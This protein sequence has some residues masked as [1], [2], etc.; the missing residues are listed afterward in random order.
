MN[1]E[2]PAVELEA[3]EEQF[4]QPGFKVYGSE[5]ESIFPETQGKPRIHLNPTLSFKAIISFAYVMLH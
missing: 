2:S 3:S 1:E 4:Y 5:P